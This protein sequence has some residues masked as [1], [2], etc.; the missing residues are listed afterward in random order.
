M[1]PILETKKIIHDVITEYKAKIFEISARKQKI[2]KT[3][4]DRIEKDK[5]D[6]LRKSLNI[7]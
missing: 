7:N 5:I 3:I 2:A 4:T 6:D 1:D